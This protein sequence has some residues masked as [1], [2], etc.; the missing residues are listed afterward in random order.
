MLQIKIESEVKCRG[1]WDSKIKGV[2]LVEKEEHIE[3][4]F[5]LLVKQDDYWEHYKYIIQVAPKVIK[6]YSD[7]SN[8]CKY[9]GKTDIDDIK[10][11]KTKIPFIIYQDLNDYE[12][13]W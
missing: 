12:F 1:H 7:L 6:D 3:K 11:L 10:K 2:I 13:K 5:K 9:V 4:L 8:L